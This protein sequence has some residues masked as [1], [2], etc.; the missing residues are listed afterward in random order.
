MPSFNLIAS[1]LKE[2]YDAAVQVQA[3]RGEY[4]YRLV[5]RNKYYHKLSSSD[6]VY[7]NPSPDYCQAIPSIG[8][9]GVIGRVCNRTSRG[10]D[11]CK[12]LCCGR[13]YQTRLELVTYKCN[14]TFVWCCSLKCQECTKLVQVTKCK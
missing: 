4:R 5:P 1:K 8:A 3:R 14:C 13:P 9:H 11:G 7:T 6:I 10:I 12:Q 2:R